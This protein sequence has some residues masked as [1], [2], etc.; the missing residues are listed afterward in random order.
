MN[1][2][3][4]L[5][6]ANLLSRLGVGL[7]EFILLFEKEYVSVG[8]MEGVGL[9]LVIFLIISNVSFESKFKAKVF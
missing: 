5:I 1:D 6:S 4:F 7:S 9:L 2:Y 8:L 3:P